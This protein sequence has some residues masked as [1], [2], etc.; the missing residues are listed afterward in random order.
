[1]RIFLS[2]LIL[3]IFRTIFKGT[4]SRYSWY[5]HPRILLCIYIG[6]QWVHQ[7]S[8][9]L[10][11]NYFLLRGTDLHPYI[12]LSWIFESVL[13]SFIYYVKFSLHCK[14]CKFYKIPWLVFI[15]FLNTS[16]FSVYT[17]CLIRTF[18]SAWL[19]VSTKKSITDE[20]FIALANL[21]LITD[22]IFVTFRTWIMFKTVFS[23][24]PIA[25]RAR[26]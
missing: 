26:T 11:D 15:S 7:S 19:W 24:S 17:D 23:V 8:E 20:I 21:I 3:V 16:A 5:H 13:L 6:S 4:N 12:S 9:H 22:G 18:V 1:M 10:H 2:E 25:F 14:A